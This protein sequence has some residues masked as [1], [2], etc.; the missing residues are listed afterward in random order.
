M[1][2]HYAYEKSTKRSIFCLK[3]IRKYIYVKLD[4]Y[5]RLFE[6]FGVGVRDPNNIQKKKVI[7]ITRTLAYIMWIITLQNVISRCYNGISLISIK[8]FLIV[9]LSFILSFLL[10]YHSIKSHFKFYK[11]I[12]KLRKL[13]NIIKTSPPHA[14]ITVSYYLFVLL[15]VLSFISNVREYDDM[16]AKLLFQVFTFDTVDLIYVDWKLA[17]FYWYLVQMALYYGTFF[18]YCFQILYIMICYNIEI[19]LRRL[20]EINKKILKLNNVTARQCATCFNLYDSILSMLHSINSILSYA[21]FV[22]NSYNVSFVV[23]GIIIVLSTGK[24]VPGIV[25]F[26]LIVNFILFSATSFAASVVHDADKEAKNLNVKLLIS[27][28]TEDRKQMKGNIEL[29]SQIC[30]APAFALTGWDFY[31][32]TRGFYLT[33]L[34][35]ITTYSLLIATIIS[36]LQIEHFENAIFLNVSQ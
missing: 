9:T 10:W 19:I 25:T 27:L 23:W 11:V 30:H 7:L 2:K 17:F 5:L 1:P 26:H 36:N 34:G 28:N 20:V 16:R 31:E 18:T 4:T 33:A 8:N 29:W 14:F 3:N 6:I 12:T 21:I 15:C 24:N 35:C 13:Q 32:F 22:V